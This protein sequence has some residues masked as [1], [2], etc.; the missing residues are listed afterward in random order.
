MRSYTGSPTVLL[1]LVSGL[2]YE[3][4]S[5]VSLNESFWGKP[6]KRNKP[7][8]QLKYNGSDFILTASLGTFPRGALCE[9][10]DNV[11]GKKLQMTTVISI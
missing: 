7:H 9:Y 11:E 5:G 4:Y 3:W 2:Q 6:P 1:V 10:T 8:V